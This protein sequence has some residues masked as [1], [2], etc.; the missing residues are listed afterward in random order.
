VAE[1]PTLAVVHGAAMM[2][3]SPAEARRSA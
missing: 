3:G 1:E 2:V